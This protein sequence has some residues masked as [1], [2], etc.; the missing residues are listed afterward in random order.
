MFFNVSFAFTASYILGFLTVFAPAGIGV[1][2][3]FLIL[4]TLIISVAARLWIITG[5]LLILGVIMVHYNRAVEKDNA[6]KKPA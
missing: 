3:G 4:I 2:E 6:T 5:E 1:R